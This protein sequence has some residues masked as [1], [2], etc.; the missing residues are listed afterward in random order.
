MPNPLVIVPGGLNTDVI[1]FGVPKIIGSGELTLGGELKI[2]PG[3]KARNMAQMTAAYLG[4]DK[5]AMIGRSSKDP[6]GLWKY[7][8]DSLRHAGV[9]ITFVKITDFESGGNK[10]PGIALIPVDRNGKNQIY[11]LPGVNM[12][13]SPAD[14]REA[15]ILFENRDHN[16][17]LLMALEMPKET[18]L[19]AIHKATENNIR[20]ILDPGGISAPID[21]FLNEKLFLLKPNEFEASIITGITITDFASAGQAAK[22]I[23][24]RGVKN[25]LITHGARGGYLFTEQGNHYIPVP[26]LSDSGIRDETGCGDQTTAILAA[27]LAEGSD[28]FSAARLSILAGSLQFQR[29]G[30]DPVER[31]ILRENASML[32]DDLKF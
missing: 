29:A 25:V 19:E 11:V 18:A 28:L 26:S 15:S 22:C 14:I 6:L 31:H 5:V 30:I 32:Y 23:Q 1:G 9:D 17:T 2:G 21:E 7:P 8:V 12:D 4:P 3:G 10:Y 24:K 16:K 13:F 20:V 27:A